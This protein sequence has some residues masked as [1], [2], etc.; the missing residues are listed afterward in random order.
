MA[1][2]IPAPCTASSDGSEYVVSDN[3][4]N[5]SA[6]D[7][8]SGSKSDTEGENRVKASVEALQRLYST[9]LPPYLCLEWQP[10]SP[11]GKNDKK[12]CQKTNN[13][14]AVY[15]G[16]LETSNIEGMHPWSVQQKGV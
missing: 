9:V 12:K 14:K 5:G 7:V 3:D 8:E 13:R 15:T 1:F 10:P 4:S 16:D 11:P 6:M 2:A